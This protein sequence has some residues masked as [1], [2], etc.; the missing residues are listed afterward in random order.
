MP[1]HAPAGGARWTMDI[2][3][4][5]PS[6]SPIETEHE[7]RWLYERMC[8]LWGLSPRAV[9]FNPCALAVHLPRD[10]M[11]RPLT[12]YLLTPKV[13]GVRQLLLLTRREDGRP[14]AVMISREMEM[15][16]IE[17]WASEAH[18]D[19]GTLLDG[20]LAWSCKDDQS[21]LTM[22][23]YAFDCM[24]MAGRRLRDETLLVRLGAVTDAVTLLPMHDDRI[25]RFSRERDAELLDFIAEDGRIVCTPDNRYGLR[26]RTK[27][28]L[29]ASEWARRLST[30]GEAAAWGEDS[31]AA[32]DGII[33]TPIQCPVYVGSHL[34]LYKWKPVG[35]ITVDVAVR[36]GALYLRSD[37]REV[38]V[39]SVGGYTL[40][41]GIGDIDD[42]VFEC[43]L[44]TVGHGFTLFPQRRR[45][46]KR[47]PNKVQTVESTIECAIDAV[48][49]DELRDWCSES[50]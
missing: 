18:F 17:V 38:R 42:G 14:V 1:R 35:S 48:S 31:G 20:E 29:R 11:S 22:E 10:R 4:L 36:D 33:F 43:T 30:Y 34:T 40:R 23:Y 45:E 21:A 49:M 12:D 3:N 39:E 6:A 25:A 15:Y 27:P 7:R 50:G 37:E 13:D 19:D 24:C 5:V 41:L 16:E 44:E 9:A 46:D 8:D 26:L 2:A 32:Y 47:S 28:M